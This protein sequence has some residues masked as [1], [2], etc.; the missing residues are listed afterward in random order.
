MSDRIR[1]IEIAVDTLPAIQALTRVSPDKA[2]DALQTICSIIET[3]QEGIDG[4][5]SPEVVQA[6]IAA[7]I[8]DFDLPTGIHN[9]FDAGGES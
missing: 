6:E 1:A 3:L 5:T 8:G 7:F 9:K 2:Q 4:R